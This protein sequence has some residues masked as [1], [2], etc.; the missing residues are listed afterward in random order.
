MIQQ[1]VFDGLCKM[2]DPAGNNPSLVPEKGKTSVVVFLDAQGL[3]LLP[4]N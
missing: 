3:L 4:V 2:L 1:V